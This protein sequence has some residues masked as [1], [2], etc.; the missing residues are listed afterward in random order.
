[1][2]STLAGLLSLRMHSDTTFEVA[3]HRNCSND[4]PGLAMF[5]CGVVFV[6]GRC[7]ARVGKVPRTLQRQSRIA[8]WP[9]D[10][11]QCSQNCRTTSARRE[12][13][14]KDYTA[15]S[16][17]AMDQKCADSG[18]AKLYALPAIDGVRQKQSNTGIKMS[19]DS[20]PRIPPKISA[21]LTTFK[22]LTQPTET[23]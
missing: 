12:F 23:C 7:A 6:T 4:T 16:W 13:S 10:R 11:Q 22:V 2:R 17:F 9:T 5:E 21:S 19:R 14:K 15:H 3:P 1:M 18:E 8:R 20:H